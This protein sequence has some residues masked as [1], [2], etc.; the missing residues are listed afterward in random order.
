MQVLQVLQVLHDLHDFSG[1]FFV[2]FSYL[3][4]GSLTYQKTSQNEIRRKIGNRV[5]DHVVTDVPWFM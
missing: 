1:I 2:A 4:K 3:E 5:H